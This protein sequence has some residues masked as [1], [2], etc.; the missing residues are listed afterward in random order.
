MI[1]MIAMIGMILIDGKANTKNAFTLF[2]LPIV[3]VHQRIINCRKQMER[4]TKQVPYLND[5]F[6]YVEITNVLLQCS[7][8][9]LNYV[10]N[11][12]L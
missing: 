11:F 12:V 9:N 8:F 6:L 7:F 4:K 5:V 2:I 10:D 3:V 1:A